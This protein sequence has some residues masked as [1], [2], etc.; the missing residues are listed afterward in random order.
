M[1]TMGDKLV[2]FGGGLNPDEEETE[3]FNS[4]HVLQSERHVTCT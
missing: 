3:Y 2:V 4:M 1:T